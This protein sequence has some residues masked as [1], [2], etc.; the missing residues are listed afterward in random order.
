MIPAMKSARTG[1]PARI[2]R[3]ITFDWHGNFS[4]PTIAIGV[5]NA[6][7]VSAFIIHEICASQ[8]QWLPTRILGLAA[9]NMTAFEDANVKPWSHRNCGTLFLYGNLSQRDPET[10]II[11]SNAFDLT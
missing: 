9:R 10:A 4:E 3:H 5:V 6:T 1:S 7:Q 2:L 11:N 8:H